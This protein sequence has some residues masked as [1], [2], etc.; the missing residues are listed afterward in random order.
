VADPLPKVLPSPSTRGLRPLTEEYHVTNPHYLHR[1]DHSLTGDDVHPHLGAVL[2]Q[3]KR[4]RPEQLDQA[5]AEQVGSGRRLGEI[6]IERGWLF[7]Q[8]IAKALAAQFGVEYV[9]INHVS[10]DLAAA[11]RLSAEVGQRCCAIGVR[12]LT[13]GTLL[14]AVADPTSAAI[15]EVEE[16][17]GGPV[18]FAITDRGDIEFAWRRILSGYKP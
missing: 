4:L 2:L 17:A 9:D 18:A 15:K 13:D 16:A 3:S 11:S 6:L 14:V 8:D 1:L 10:V 12:T 5:L 7:P